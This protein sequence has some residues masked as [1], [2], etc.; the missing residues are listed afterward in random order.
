MHAARLAH[1][2]RLQRLLTVLADG[3]EHSTQELIGA[4]RIC[5]VNSC[6]AELRAQ[7]L[8]I[9]CRRQG[10]AWYYRLG[11][12]AAPARRAAAGAP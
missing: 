5:A 10:G 9:A 11:L 8:P 3:R 4:A 1:S 2:P 12:P 7:G 6:A